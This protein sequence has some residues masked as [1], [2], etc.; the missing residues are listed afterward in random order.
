MTNAEPVLVLDDVAV[1]YAPRSALFGRQ[2]PSVKAVD[3]VSLSIASGETLAL[4]GESG[5][6][7]STLSNAV[8]GLVPVTR[9]S[10]QVRGTELS[11]AD[12]STLRQAR[13]HVQMISRIRR[14]RSTRA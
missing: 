6:G 7:K 2:G 11:G 8:V 9:G 1:H 5:C 13:R 3:G 12:A 14:S 10:V 4:V